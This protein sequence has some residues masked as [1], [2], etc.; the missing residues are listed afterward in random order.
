[1]TDEQLDRLRAVADEGS[2]TPLAHAGEGVGTVSVR[3]AAKSIGV[4]ER[5]IRR[6]IQDGILPAWKQETE[7]GYEWRVPVSSLDAGLPG[8]HPRQTASLPGSVDQGGG[9]PPA[10]QVAVVGAPAAPELLKALEMVDRLTRENQQLAGQLGFTQAKL[11]DAQEENQQ[12]RLLPAP[13]DEPTPEPP[14]Q[15]ERVSWWKRLW[16]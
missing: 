6:R 8:T 7:H 10:Q 11:Q 1:M 5:T 3:D 2:A 4:S 15:P 12:L 16:S 9:R 13:K 14:A